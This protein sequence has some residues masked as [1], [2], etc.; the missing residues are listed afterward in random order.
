M[1]NKILI[2]VAHRDDEVLGAGGT[3]LKHKKR[4]DDVYCLF[5]GDKQ[6]CR[7]NLDIERESFD[8]SKKLGFR[9]IYS[10]DF[11]D[12]KFDTVPLIKIVNKIEE[13]LEKINP[14]IVYTHFQNDVNI[15]H[16]R[17]LEAVITACR[18]C[19]SHC[20][21]RIYSFEVL[22]STEW[23]L[24]GKKFTPNV[25]VDISSEIEEKMNT[26]SIYKSEVREYPHPRSKEGIKILAKYRGLECGKEYAEAFELIR[27]IKE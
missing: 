22:S 12:N 6:L 5:L 19:N 11:P 27:E 21:K 7:E 14:N 16:K 10:A 23:Q 2:I 24:K 26:M 8:A 13:Y 17:T 9:E 4:G 3:I 20:P 1:K 15:D 25:Y 18:P